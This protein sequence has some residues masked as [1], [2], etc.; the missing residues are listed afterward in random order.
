M[1]NIS[2]LKFIEQ[3]LKELINI[4]DTKTQLKKLKKLKQSYIKNGNKFIKETLNEPLLKHVMLGTYDIDLEKHRDIINEFNFK[5]RINEQG[6]N[7]SRGHYFTNGDRLHDINNNEY[8]KRFY[9]NNINKV[10]INGVY[11]HIHIYDPDPESDEEEEEEQKQYTIDEIKQHTHNMMTNNIIN[12]I[13][14]ETVINLTESK[15]Y[16]E[17]MNLDFIKHN[18]HFNKKVLD[19]SYNFK[20]GDIIYKKQHHKDY[21]NMFEVVRTTGKSVYVRQLEPQLVIHYHDRDDKHNNRLLFKF[22]KGQYANNNPATRTAKKHY[23]NKYVI[24]DFMFYD[25]GY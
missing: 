16:Y 25:S 24:N 18:Q 15:I 19:H 1:E 14:N 20:I 4:D 13:E 6:S 11:V 22:I 12:R 21:N 17:Y 8:L 2:E 3:T 9:E 23:L 5:Y 7:G 10:K